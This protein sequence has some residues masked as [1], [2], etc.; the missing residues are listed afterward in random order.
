ML[1]MNRI[2]MACCGL[3]SHRVRARAA[4]RKTERKRY[5]ERMKEGRI[6]LSCSSHERMQVPNEAAKTRAAVGIVAL[7]WILWAN[8]R[9][10][11]ASKTTLRPR[12]R[13]EV[14]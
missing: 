7:V 14:D 5:T 11:S 4:S 3:S 10:Q 8:G 1:Q 13:K 2:G 6:D 9:V 12:I